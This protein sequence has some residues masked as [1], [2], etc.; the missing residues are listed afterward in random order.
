MPPPSLT[1]L[2]AHTSLVLLN[3]DAVS[4]ILSPCPAAAFPSTHPMPAWHHAGSAMAS[5]LD[6]APHHQPPRA[7]TPGSLQAAILGSRNSPWRRAQGFFPSLLSIFLF[8]TLFP[9]F[10]AAACPSIGVR[11]AGVSG[12]QTSRDGGEWQQG[13][14]AHPQAPRGRTRPLLTS[15]NNKSGGGSG[16][17]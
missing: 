10:E 7:R 17:G 15:K 9:H 3:A 6:A 12:A 5:C 4:A 11:V 16:S 13:P 14:P 1:P 8:L 2:C